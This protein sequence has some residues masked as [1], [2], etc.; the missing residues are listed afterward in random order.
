ML[1][2]F[3][4][5]YHRTVLDEAGELLCEEPSSV[6]GAGA[7]S[8]GEANKRA[9]RHPCQGV[10][11]QGQVEKG[12]GGRQCGRRE[13]HGTGRARLAR[14]RK[15]GKMENNGVSEL[16]TAGRPTM[17]K[18][19][20]IDPKVDTM[21]TR[22]R[23]IMNNSYWVIEVLLVMLSGAGRAH[24]RKHH[25]STVVRSHITNR[26][27]GRRYIRLN[28]SIVYR[29]LSTPRRGAHPAFGMFALIGL[30]YWLTNRRT[31]RSMNAPRTASSKP[32]IHRWMRI[33]RWKGRTYKPVTDLEQASS[34]MPPMYNQPQ[35]PHGE[36]VVQPSPYDPPTFEEV[37]LTVPEKPVPGRTSL[38]YM[39]KDPYHVAPRPGHEQKLTTESSPYAASVAGSSRVP[40]PIP[41]VYQPPP[42]PPT[43]DIDSTI[44]VTSY[45]FTIYAAGPGGGST[46][47][48][49]YNQQGR[50]ISCP[51]HGWAIA[52]IVVVFS[53]FTVMAVTFWLSDRKRKMRRRAV[54]RSESTARPPRIWNP[55]SRKQTQ[56]STSDPVDTDTSSTLPVYATPPCEPPKPEGTYLTLPGVPEKPQ[57]EHASS[58]SAF[59]NLQYAISQLGREPEEEAESSPDATRPASTPS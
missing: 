31:T 15:S 35:Y 40:S 10:G 17:E 45:L 55:F 51:L 50:P 7:W 11:Q 32:M 53:L 56:Y 38:E 6:A 26:Q 48:K 5:S 2:S 57:P 58:D 9:V 28:L 59:M 36:P 39:Y 25:T 41:T 23:T 44:R 24:A 13:A 33:F 46:K 22:S 43:T 14:T 19:L 54:S 18:P 4:A 49:C 29:S 42:Y 52:I 37:S 3:T 1:G 27:E 30:F 34:G 12:L 21:Q 47:H 20:H 8:K 16:Q